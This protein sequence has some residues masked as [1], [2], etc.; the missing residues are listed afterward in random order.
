MMKRRLTR[1]IPLL[2]S[3]AA[4]FLLLYFVPRL[5]ASTVFYFLIGLG[6]LTCL[7]SSALSF[8]IPPLKNAYHGV[9]GIIL[10]LFLFFDPTLWSEQAIGPLW[11]LMGALALFNGDNKPKTITS[12]VI[13]LIAFVMAFIPS[14]RFVAYAILALTGFVFAFIS[15]DSRTFSIYLSIGLAFFN[16]AC[17]FLPGKGGISFANVYSIVSLLVG[18]GYSLIHSLWEV[19]KTNVELAQKEMVLSRIE[20]KALKEEIQPHFLLNALNNVRV[21]YHESNEKGTEL[22]GELRELEKRIYKTIDTPFIPLSEEIQ[23]IQSLIA[24]HNVDSG[25]NIKLSLDVED[26]SLPVPPMLLEPL[27]ENSLQHSGIVHQ[28]D[29]TIRIRER[30]EYGIALIQVSDN[31]EGQPLP[32]NSRGIGLSNVMKRVSLL[33]N[34]HMSIDSNEGGTMIEI[35]FAPERS[36]GNPFNRTPIITEG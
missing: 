11:I 30:E 36:E 27:V 21:A 20:E 17:G 13:F 5:W 33:E 6:A 1:L 12:L 24:L 4:C 32:S 29:G 34:G 15:K 7:L 26:G 9:I 28:E 16:A 25:Y 3:I 23:I 2:I 22:L 31:G 35:R 8:G 10:A 19:K 18:L 14:V